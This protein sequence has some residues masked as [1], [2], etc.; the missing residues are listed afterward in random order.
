MALQRTMPR[1]WSQFGKQN[2]H[3]ILSGCAIL[4][5]SMGQ[6]PLWIHRVVHHGCQPVANSSKLVSQQSCGCC[7]TIDR[8]VASQPGSIRIAHSR[9]FTSPARSLERSTTSSSE[10]TATSSQL[11][12]RSKA[13][14]CSHCGLCFLL[15]QN[16][17]PRCYAPPSL[18][19]SFLHT[20]VLPA[21][22]GKPSLFVS[23]LGA[24]G[25]PV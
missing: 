24:R 9:S 5:I 8:S 10:P 11:E 16:A 18:G 17:W 15:S 23:G 19:P 13:N 14:C 3:S 7:Q 22:C 21:F 1:T 20:I 2:L 4:L 6:I 25:P 12:L